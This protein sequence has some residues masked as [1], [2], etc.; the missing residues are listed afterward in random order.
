MKQQNKI[1]V[2]GFIAFVIFYVALIAYAHNGDKLLYKN[3]RYIT[4]T[5]LKNTYGSGNSGA[6]YKYNV[7]GERYEAWNYTDKRAIEGERYFIIYNKNNPQN[8][9]LFLDCPVPDTLIDI[10]KEGW[11]KIPVPEYQKKVDSIFDKRLN[12]WLTQF[13]PR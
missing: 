6:E 1:F 8:S 9:E 7:L 2:Y 12:G 11:D 5:V 4:A 10:P 3:A 13:F